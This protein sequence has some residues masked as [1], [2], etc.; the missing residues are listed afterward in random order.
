MS[1]ANQTRGIKFPDIN[2]AD[3]SADSASFSMSAGDFLEVYTEPGESQGIYTG[4]GSLVG[5]VR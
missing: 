3:L 2:P 5:T 4:L 1:S